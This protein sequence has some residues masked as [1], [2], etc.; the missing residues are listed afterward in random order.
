MKETYGISRI[1]M[2]QKDESGRYLPFGT[3][4]PADFGV[5][6]LKDGHYPFDA[7]DL[8]QVIL[9]CEKKEAIIS[10]TTK[11]DG[12][13]CVSRATEEYYNMSNGWTL[14][15]VVVITVEKNGAHFDL[16][17]NSKIIGDDQRYFFESIDPRFDK[18]TVRNILGENGE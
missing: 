2:R 3:E 15:K 10:N 4:W 1:E 9:D 18:R 5:C 11:Y 12:K 13:Y 8:A 7:R 16:I 6:K 17:C 14:D